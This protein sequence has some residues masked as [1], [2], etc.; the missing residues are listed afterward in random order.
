M[1]ERLCS[2]R[3]TYDNV[4]LDIAFKYSAFQRLTM[5]Q[6]T[7]DWIMTDNFRN[8]RPM[9]CDPTVESSVCQEVRYQ[10]RGHAMY[11]EIAELFGWE[12]IYKFRYL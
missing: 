3:N 2:Y 10:H 12:A 7:I 1:V 5:D 6:T 8:N 11:V 9:E 4:P